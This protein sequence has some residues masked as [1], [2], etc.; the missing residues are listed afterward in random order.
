[1]TQGQGLRVE[2]QPLGVETHTHFFIMIILLTSQGKGTGQR[3]ILQAPVLL[4]K[5]IHTEHPVLKVC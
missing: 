1:M 4:D 3:P 2:C 5:P